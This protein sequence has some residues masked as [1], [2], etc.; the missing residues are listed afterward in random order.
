[1]LVAG[2]RDS[3]A[4]ADW[5]SPRFGIN[6][7]VDDLLL[8]VLVLILVLDELT[9]PGCPGGAV[10]DQSGQGGDAAQH[11]DP[12]L[13]RV[14]KNERVTAEPFTDARSAM[15]CCADHT[16]PEPKRRDLAPQALSPLT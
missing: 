12:G 3:A 1:M 11:T 5:S 6:L 13:G 16:K 7:V 4:G 14:G 2:H 15:V 9:E 10:E 8:V